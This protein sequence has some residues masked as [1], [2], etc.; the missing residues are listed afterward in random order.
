MPLR[1][2]TTNFADPAFVARIKAQDAAAL[3]AVVK[4]YLD[5]IFRAAL[6]AGLNQDQAE[7]TTQATFLTFIESASRFEGRSHVRTWLFGILYKKIAEAR[8]RTQKN[9]QFDDIDVIM[10]QRFDLHGNWVRAPRPAD[11]NLQDAEL[12]QHIED[13][14]EQAT[15]QQRLAFLLREVEGFASEEICKTIGVTITN[16]GV[17]LYRARNK[18]RECLEKRGVER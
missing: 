15:L 3:E 7:D 14:L 18:L 12:R 16:L 4:V 17:L 10:E 6:G 11:L 13:C 8:R 1:P 9:G 2:Q 5:Q